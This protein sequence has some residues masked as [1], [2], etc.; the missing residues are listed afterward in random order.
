MLQWKWNWRFDL[1]GVALFAAALL[2]C[3]ALANLSLAKT[4]V[5]QSACGDVVGTYLIEIF[6]DPQNRVVD[7][8]SLMSYFADGN[9]LFVDSNQAGVPDV[10]NPFTDAA[11]NWTCVLRLGAPKSVVALAL[12]F[13]LPGTLGPEQSIARLDFYDVTVDSTAGTIAGAGTL[14]FFPFDGDPLNPGPNTATPFFF[15]GR[16]VSAGN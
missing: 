16:R 5:D 8:R 13:V 11:G 10:F 9:F 14:R 12:D 3:L 15:D 1:F 7:A 6:D 4:R 2:L